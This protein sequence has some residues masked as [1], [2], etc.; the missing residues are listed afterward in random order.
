MAHEQHIIAFGERFTSQTLFSCFSECH[1][2][3]YMLNGG[4]GD[5]VRGTVFFL[6]QS[7][8]NRKTICKR[9][10]HGTTKEG[11]STRAICSPKEAA[12]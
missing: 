4:D 6:A 11:Y 5:I 2:I 9:T 1:Q 3:R 8:G 12:E 7:A 10:H